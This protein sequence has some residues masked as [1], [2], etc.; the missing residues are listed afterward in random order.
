M[1]RPSGI[2]C[3]GWGLFFSIRFFPTK[4]SVFF[5]PKKKRKGKKKNVAAARVANSF[6]HPLDR[7]QTFFYL[8]F[9][10]GPSQYTLD[11]PTDY[12]TVI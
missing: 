12:F 8:F 1:E 4:I 5:L 2:I 3:A 10:F 6:G 7:K 9:L 11:L